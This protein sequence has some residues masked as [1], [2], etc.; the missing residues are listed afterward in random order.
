MGDLVCSPCPVSHAFIRRLARCSSLSSYGHTHDDSL[1]LL[2]GM[3][4]KVLLSDTKQTLCRS[5]DL[6]KPFDKAWKD[7]EAKL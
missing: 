5:Q 6:K 1:C 4:T 7:Y 3:K 2:S